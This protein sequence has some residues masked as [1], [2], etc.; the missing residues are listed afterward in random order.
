VT[1]NLVLITIGLVFIGMLYRQ[2]R[3]DAIGGYKSKVAE[4]TLDK[5]RT[6][7]EE[8][9]KGDKKLEGDID[10]MLSSPMAWW[11]RRNRN[12]SDKEV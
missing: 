6:V 4:N 5:L 7:N 9:I 2:V 12:G 8:D 1:S 3:K 11:L 10:D